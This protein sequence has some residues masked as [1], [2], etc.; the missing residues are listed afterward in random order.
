MVKALLINEFPNAS[1]YLKIHELIQNSD[2]C[3]VIWPFFVIQSVFAAHQFPCLLL[4]FTEVSI[5]SF[6]L[7]PVDIVNHC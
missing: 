2:L 1:A 7:E 6:G 5:L 4:A 3:C